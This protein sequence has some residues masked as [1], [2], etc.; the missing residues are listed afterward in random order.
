VARLSPAV[1]D[2]VLGSLDN[3][4][5]MKVDDFESTILFV[6]NLGE[7][8]AFY[9]DLLGLVVR[10]EDDIIVVVDGPSG[11]IVLHRNDRGHDERGIFPAGTTAGAASLR[12]KVEEPEAW[13]EEAKRVGVPVLWPV[14]EAMWGRF[15]VVADPDGRPVALAKMNTL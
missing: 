2:Q 14:Q 3:L 7:A 13:E 15:V 6:K 10:F 12:F 8:R 5:S 1:R 11:R 9:V 4:S